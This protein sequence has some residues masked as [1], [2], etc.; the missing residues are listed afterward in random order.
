MNKLGKLVRLTKGGIQCLKENG[1][2]YTSR[3][4]KEKWVNHQNRIRAEKNS[5]QAKGSDSLPAEDKCA[6]CSAQNYLDYVHY[7]EDRQWVKYSGINP[8]FVPINPTDYRFTE[9]S[10][11]LIAWYLPQFYQFEVNNKYHG[12]GFTEWTNSSQALPQFTGHYQPHIPYDVGYYDLTNPDTMKRQAFLARKY[13]IYAF[14]FH[15]YWFSG[16]KTLELPAQILLEHKEIDIHFCFDWATENWTSA[17]DG[18]TKEIIFEQKIQ[19]GDA[20]KFMD[21]ILPFMKDER[22]VRIDGRPVLTIYRCDMFPR[23]RFINMM[24]EMR[25][26]ARQNGFPD[27]YLMLTN[28]EN[29]GDVTEWGMDALVEF[30][31]CFVYPLCGKMTPQGYVNPNFRGD[32][33]DITPFIEKRSYLQTYKTAKVFRSALTGFDNTS[34]RATTGCQIIMNNT[35]EAYKKWLTGLLSE[36]QVFHSREENIIFLNNWNEWAEGSHLEPDMRYG[37]AYLQATREAMEEIRPLDTGVIDRKIQENRQKGITENHYYIFCAESMGDI[38]AAEPIARCLKD[39]DPDGKIHWIVRKAFAE[40]VKYNPNIDETIEIEYLAQGM[41]LCKKLSRQQ[42]NIIV[43]THFDGRMCSK[44]RKVHINK[45]NPQVNE[46]TYLYY[47]SLLASFCLSAGLPPVKEGPVFWQKPGVKLPDGLPGEY[48]VFHC[49]SAENTKDWTDEK[50]N[51]L[52]KWLMRDGVEIVE[53]GFEPIVKTEDPKYHDL[54][55]LRDLQVIAEVIRNARC[56]ISIDSGF[57]HFANSFGVYGILIFGAYKNFEHPKMYTGGYAEGNAAII[58]PE[59][60][61]D[62]ALCVDVEQVYDAWCDR[63]GKK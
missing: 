18:G 41:D 12:Q 44:T 9:D 63:L 1:I 61:E 34:R 6:S 11:R 56:L 38:V 55:N 43:D 21:D 26:I 8:E 27:L 51:Y 50:W 60:A 10:A 28:R 5:R 48:V 33:F 17:W 15:W 4:L 54:T 13:G 52:A 35:P 40:I 25:E 36:S 49:R 59:K 53:L 23:K 39:R 7:L 45:N 2:S 42:E 14:C 46:G 47:G 62:H 37:Y 57:A 16:V 24:N 3:H 32:L 19:D 29:M 20:R 31:P 58:Y 22:Y 30:A